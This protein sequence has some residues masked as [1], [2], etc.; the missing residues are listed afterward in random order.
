MARTR[1]NNK[2]TEV[3]PLSTSIVGANL[4]WCPYIDGDC[5]DRDSKDCQ[6]CVA[7][8]STPKNL[9]ELIEKEDKK[10]QEYLNSIQATINAGMR[11]SSK[12]GLYHTLAE[13]FQIYKEDLKTSEEYEAYL[14][15]ELRYAKEA[16][17]LTEA[18]YARDMQLAAW[19]ESRLQF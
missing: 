15:G 4:S 14:D 18:A 3:R 6:W 19:V 11:Y 5:I 13:L 2:T 16:L 8:P 7:N 17:D 10:Q 12:E 1:K 9:V